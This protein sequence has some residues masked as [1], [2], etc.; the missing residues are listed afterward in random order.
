MER[1]N[2]LLR[3]QTAVEAEFGPH[4]VNVIIR[5]WRIPVFAMS[6]DLPGVGVCETIGMDADNCR[7]EISGMDVMDSC[8]GEKNRSA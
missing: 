6:V 8:V 5:A 2:P 1:P 4:H 3:G 7:R